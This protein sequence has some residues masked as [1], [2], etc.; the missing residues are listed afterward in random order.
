MAKRGDS[1]AKAVVESATGFVIVVVTAAVVA[2]ATAACSSRARRACSAIGISAQI[3][4]DCAVRVA[5]ARV[6]VVIAGTVA[7]TTQGWCAGGGCV[8][9]WPREKA[10]QSCSVG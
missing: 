10:G 2:I 8:C 7:I 6:A 1:T 9:T 4:P 3:P 5:A